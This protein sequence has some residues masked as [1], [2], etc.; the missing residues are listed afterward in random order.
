MSNQTYQ[1]LSDF[2]I[3]NSYFKLY[4]QS[5][6]RPI[7]D[8]QSPRRHRVISLGV[9]RQRV[10][11]FGRCDHEGRLGA[12][13][14]WVRTEVLPLQFGQLA[15]K[16]IF[17]LS[18]SLD[19][20]I[21]GQKILFEDEVQRWDNEMTQHSI[22][23]RIS[24]E[25]WNDMWLIIIQVYKRTHTHTTHIVKHTTAEKRGFAVYRRTVMQSTCW[26]KYNHS[27]SAN[28]LIIKKEREHCG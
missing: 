21:L 13:R 8:C 28:D 10:L 20:I 22:G 17:D 9:R 5:V 12:H 7:V 16:G 24:N 1:R 6:C 15:L 11:L 18:R 19:V 14:G 2:M 26:S 27:F 3:N 4:S 25:M 23:E